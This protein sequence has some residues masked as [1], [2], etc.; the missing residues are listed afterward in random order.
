M[1]E[2]PKKYLELET[3]YSATLDQ[4]NEFKLIVRKSKLMTKFFYCE[5]PDSYYTKKGTSSFKRFRKTVHPDQ[6]YKEITTKVK[7]EGAKSNISRVEKNLRVD[8]NTDELIVSMILDDG[9]EFDFTIWKN[10][11]IYSN[12]HVTLVFYFFLIILDHERSSTSYMCLYCFI[13]ILP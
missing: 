2:N 13:A 6:F 3:K 9:Y 4:L 12:D 11:H 7:P 5:G 10:C 1:S 8:G